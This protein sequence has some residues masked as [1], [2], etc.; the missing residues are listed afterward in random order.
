[1]IGRASKKVVGGKLLRIE[2]EYDDIIHRVTLS[3]DFF[4]YPEEALQYI[5]KN[6][7][8]YSVKETNEFFSNIIN[9]VVKKNKI[10]LIGFTVDD[11]T[12][13]LKEALI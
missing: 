11:I 5:E 10:Q 9:G 1:M 8:G 2:I 6:I 7:E 3:G 12:E 13:T 4:V